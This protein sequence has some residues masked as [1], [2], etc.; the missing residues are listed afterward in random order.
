MEDFQQLKHR[1]GASLLQQRLDKQAQ[2]QARQTHQGE[3][4]FKL[5]RFHH[6]SIDRWAERLLKLCFLWERAHRNI[7]QIQLSVSLKL[8]QIGCC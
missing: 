4:I 2:H 5:E 7:F 1:L 6:I 8:I 3:G